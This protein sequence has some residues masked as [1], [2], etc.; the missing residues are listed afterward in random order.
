MTDEVGRQRLG[1]ESL[2]HSSARAERAKNCVIPPIRTHKRS[3][4]KKVSSTDKNQLE[5]VLEAEFEIHSQPNIGENEVVDDEEEKEL[6][7]E[8]DR[9]ED[10]EEEE[11]NELDVED[12]QLEDEDEQPPPPSPPKRPK[13]QRKPK[14][15]RHK[16]TPIEPPV[17]GYGGGPSDISL[18]PRFGNHTAA[19]L[20]LGQGGSK[21]ALDT[22]L[23]SEMQNIET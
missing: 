13:R 9:P 16:V 12:E 4:W 21:Y 6:E 1:R 3:K 23:E 20:C 7:G 19:Y 8:E 22:M 14:T 10:E 15:T 11:D 2:A 17:G 18:L 5:G